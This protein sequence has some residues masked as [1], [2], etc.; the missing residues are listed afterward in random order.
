VG[1]HMVNDNEQ[2]VRDG[3][4]SFVLAHAFD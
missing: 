1:Q 3:H 4:K 2:A